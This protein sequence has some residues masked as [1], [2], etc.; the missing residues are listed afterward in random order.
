MIRILVDTSADFTLEEIREKQLECVP[1]HIALNGSDYRDCYDLNKEQFYELLL[2]AEQFPATSQPSPQDFV[3]VFER[4]KEA[5]DEVVAILLSSKLSGTFQSA[6]LA[7]EIVE[8]D[9]IYLVDSLSAT[10]CN[11][12]LAEF[13]LKRVQEG[14]SASEIAVEL[15]EL[16]GR[17]RIVAAVDTLEYLYKGGRLS[18]TAAMIGEM[19]KIKPLITLTEGEVA[20]FGKCLGKNKAISMLLKQIGECKIDE[21]FPVYTLFTHGTDNC[22]VFEERLKEAGYEPADRLQLGATIG[23]HIGP[24]AYGFLFVEKAEH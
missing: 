15:E 10:H 13:A 6:A 7:K 16:R 8:Y 17:L 5:G 4:A 11:R 14:A 23:T 2:S 24:G 19:A 9:K 3:D 18:R 12:I 22:A 20:V 21:N 1:M